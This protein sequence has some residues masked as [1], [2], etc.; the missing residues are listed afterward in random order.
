MGMEV[1]RQGD[2]LAAVHSATARHGGGPHCALQVCQHVQRQFSCVPKAAIPV[3]AHELGTTTGHI[4]SLVSFYSFLHETPRGKYDIYIS[5]GVLDHVLGSKELLA[6][7]C[8][9][10]GVTAGEP[11]LDG[12]VTVATA[13]CTGLCDQ[14]PA[15]LVNGRPLT[16]LNTERIDH[17][18]Q[19]VETAIPLERWPRDYFQVES[20][21]RRQDRL[22]SQSLPMGAGLHT[23]HE[24]SCEGMLEELETAD[25]RGRG[26]AGFPTAAKWRLCREAKGDCHYV[27]CNADEGE[28]GTFKDRVLLSD[29][30]DDVIEGMTLCGRTIGA[31]KGFI[32]LRGEYAW[33]R[34]HLEWVL[35]RRRGDAFLGDNILGQDDW[36]FD[37]EIHTG[38]GAYICGEESAL[39]ESLEGKRGTPRNRPPYPVTSGYFGQPTVVN[40]VETFF[41]S[42]HIAA[43]GG[44][45]FTEGGSRGTQL[46]SVGGDCPYPG[47]YEFPLGCTVAEILEAAGAVDTQAVQV[48][49]ASGELLLPEEFQRTIEPRSLRTNGSFIILGQQ[50]ELFQAAANFTRFFAHET[51]G[52][53]A[54][55]RTGTQLARSVVDRMAAGRAFGR[56]REAIDR[57]ID[58]T[59]V[60]SHCGLGGSALNP[61]RDLR[62]KCPEY[63]RSLFSE[64]DDDVLHFDLEQELSEIRIITGE[65]GSSTN[66]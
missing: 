28:P 15:G 35:E 59:P 61:L 13:S 25:L 20:F 6:R 46:H 41:T 7:L 47:V 51:C 17:I 57:L 60:M 44:S 38:A 1:F 3:I 16:R 40:N 22:L 50:R 55:C 33:L 14:G 37:I 30:T 21:I 56:D 23:M 39:I 31:E 24:L 53:C 26:G 11:R 66:G 10:L 49:G 2:L 36:H 27:V 52:F 29:Y 19:L 45:W 63:Y 58:V 4:V 18:I 42:A 5:D 43:R 32:Y 12:R 34:P 62:D 65:T 9:G 48:G 8:L 54:P 64:D